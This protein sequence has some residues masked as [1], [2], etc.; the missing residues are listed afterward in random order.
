VL[1]RRRAAKRREP[2]S[3]AAAMGLRR[4]D[5]IRVTVGGGRPVAEVTGAGHRYPSTV[6]VPL[7][8]AN[9]LAAA[10]IPLLVKVR[11]TARHTADE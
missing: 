4:V 5:Y 11:P 10:G 8:T 2:I 1:R 3:A 7:R 6:R 9:R